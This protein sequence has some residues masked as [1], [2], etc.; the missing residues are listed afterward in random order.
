MLLECVVCQARFE[1]EKTGPGR[2]P[3]FCS[4]ECKATQ[5]ARQT[6]ECKSRV[7]A[8]ERR[9]SYPKPQPKPL[10]QYDCEQCCSRYTAAAGSMGNRFCSG[11]CRD[12]WHLARKAAELSAR[13]HPVPCPCCSTVFKPAHPLQRYCKRKCEKKVQNSNK[14]HRR[15]TA[16]AGGKVNPFA[17]FARDGWKCKACGV[18]T[19]RDKRGMTSNDAPELDHIV[20]L[21]KGGAHSYENTQCLCR[22]CNRS[23]GAKLVA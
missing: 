2:L 21:S 19:P 11:R 9:N 5:R 18:D 1:F 13:L 16:V 3:R 15:R 14:N 4:A 10:G 7:A 17:V 22:G 20:P 12:L 23:K 6:L 8:G